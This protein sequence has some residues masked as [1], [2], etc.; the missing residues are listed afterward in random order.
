MTRVGFAGRVD[1]ESGLAAVSRGFFRHVGPEVIVQEVEGR[2]TNGADVE[3]L[4]NDCDVIYVLDRTY[5]PDLL[6][7]AKE[8]GVPT[9][10]HTPSPEWYTPD[11]DDATEVWV[12]TRW[13]MDLTR[14]AAPRRVP[15]PVTVR[16]QPQEPAGRVS[17]PLF[18]LH[19]PGDKAHDKNGT[20]L[21]EA[22]IPLLDPGRVSVTIP[23]RDGWFGDHYARGVW[24]LLLF[25]RRFG[26]G[27]IPA[28]EAAAAGVPTVMLGRLPEWLWLG[29]FSV[30]VTR[31][32][33][34]RLTGRDVQRCDADPVDLADLLH[35][36]AAD[37]R[38]VERAGHSARVR[39]GALAW[40]RW[41]PVIRDE[42]DRMAGAR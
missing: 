24:D 36:L 4:V 26:S 33:D 42:L 1:E 15:L 5:S 9:V 7:A 18:V 17:L 34:V 37:R 30:P 39:A 41:G 12:P 19:L 8:A 23:D 35:D 2:R 21:V 14:R 38:R 25:P 3:W 31:Q 6:P 32:T 22:T 11:W 28:D 40:D 20:E 16:E 13:R 29:T 27:C 10:L